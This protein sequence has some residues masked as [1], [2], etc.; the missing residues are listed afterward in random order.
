MPRKKRTNFRTGVGFALTGPNPQLGDNEYTLPR[1][2]AANAPEYA[3]AGF[4]KWHLGNTANTPWTKGGWPFWA[5]V[6]GPQ[7]ASYTNWTKIK[8]GTSTASTTYVTTDQVNEATAW[9]NEQEAA[10]KPWFAWV[11]FNAPHVPYH[12]P[13]ANLLSPRFAPKISVPA[14]APET[15]RPGPSPRCLAKPAAGDGR[16]LCCARG[17]LTRSPTRSCSG[18]CANF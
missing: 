2:F 17:R 11:A 6:N 3:L 16:G 7:P 8:N 12:K 18:G 1:A 9:I 15:T 10:D 5:G 13:P 4:G 14:G